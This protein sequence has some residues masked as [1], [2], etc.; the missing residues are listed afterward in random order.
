M[1]KVRGEDEAEFLEEDRDD[2]LYHSV[3]K[4]LFMISQYMRD[5]QTAVSLLKKES[6]GNMVMN[7]GS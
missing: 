3:S 7:G 2:I 4:L 1:F 5:K 6:N